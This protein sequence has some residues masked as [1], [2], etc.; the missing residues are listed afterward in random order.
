MLW[1]NRSIIL[2]YSIHVWIDM[3][4]VFFI[5]IIV[6]RK[7]AFVILVINSSFIFVVFFIFRFLLAVHK[8]FLWCWPSCLVISGIWWW[9][10]LDSAFVILIWCL[11]DLWFYYLIIIAIFFLF[12]LWIINATNWIN[13]ENDEKTKSNTSKGNHLLFSSVKFWILKRS[14]SCRY[15][16]Y[17]SWDNRSILDIYCFKLNQSILLNIALCVHCL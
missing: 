16:I 9:L 4:V 7:I 3:L 15:Q 6:Y 13:N 11:M 8:L 2:W 10:L 14:Y 5:G 1:L 12:I 17:I